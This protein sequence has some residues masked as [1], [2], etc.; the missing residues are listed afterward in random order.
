M[1]M[2]T[3][4]KLIDFSEAKINSIYVFEFQNTFFIGKL[5]YFR[6]G[7]I[8]IED[9]LN[10]SYRYISPKCDLKIYMCDKIN[11]IG[12]PF[13]YNGPCA[14]IAGVG[15]VY[16]DTCI[17]Y[18]EILSTFLIKQ[19]LNQSPKQYLDDVFKFISKTS[20]SKT[21]FVGGNHLSV[22]P[23]HRYARETRMCSIIFDAHRDYQLNSQEQDMTHANFL[24]YFEDL[25]NVMVFGYRDGESD[26]FRNCKIYNIEQSCAFL[27]QI[28][29]LKKAGIKFY[30]DIDI[31]VLDPYYFSATAC[32][33]KNGIS[34]Q[35]LFSLIK[36]IGFDCIEFVSVEEYIPYLGDDHC[37]KIIDDIIQLFL[38]GWNGYE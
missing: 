31:D 34:P 30:I 9:I 8:A 21:I 22:L 3:I 1:E 23:L 18:H 37:N 12:I 33:I 16:N 14:T 19:N 17:R 29:K 28:E 10:N 2:V 5:L 27:R 32:T 11:M 4:S 24:N 38:K 36:Q 13:A 7:E 26:S 35:R 15:K 25:S 6:V 20:V